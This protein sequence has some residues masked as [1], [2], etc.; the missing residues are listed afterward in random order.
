MRSSIAV[1]ALVC[2]APFIARM[3]AADAPQGPA[4]PQVAAPIAPARNT[5][6][7]APARNSSPALPAKAA[8]VTLKGVC[9]AGQ[10]GSGCKTVITRE[11]LD[12]YVNAFAPDAAEPA[13]G[14]MAVQYARTVALAG[15]AEKQGMEKDPAVAK[16]LASQLRLARLRVL[17]NAYLKTMA[18]QGGG[19]TQADI[20]R[21]YDA[22]KAQFETVQALRLSTPLAVPTEGGRP[23]ERAAVRSVMEDLRKR[24]VSGEDFQK[25]QQEAYNAL[26]VQAP[27]PIMAPIMLQ[28]GS[29]QGDEAQVFEMKPGDISPVLDSAAAVVIIKVI[30][31]E[32]V[33]MGSARAEI[34]AALMR[35][36]TQQ[37][38]VELGKKIT[39]QF[40]LQYFGMTAQPEIFSPTAFSVAA[41]R[42]PARR[43]SAFRT[44]T[45]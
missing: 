28:R 41:G 9:A 45:R 29:L 24:A 27:A 38:M 12:G 37:Q 6:S 22:H 33:P 36:R 15:L 35:D 14:R 23:L 25:L 20:Q 11:E 8:V 42:A 16:E 7:P 40:D 43:G 17:S 39:A 4:R 21:Y 34:E 13:R 32:T 2:T 44:V 5:G 26:H 30:S 18:S 1:A 10:T 31:K 19:V 3:S